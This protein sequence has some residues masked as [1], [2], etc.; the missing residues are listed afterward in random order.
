MY[1]HVYR[2]WQVQ[3]LL[4]FRFANCSVFNSFRII[5]HALHAKSHYTCRC[6]LICSSGSHTYKGF[7][8]SFQME[9]NANKL[10]IGINHGFR[11][12]TGN[13]LGRGGEAGRT[14]KLQPPPHL[15]SIL[16]CL[17][18]RFIGGT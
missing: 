3:S 1:T 15:P 10:Q 7:D 13:S 12:V 2:L 17:W 4:F 5:H 14:G 6:N 18:T 9:Q 11:G 8:T 16:L